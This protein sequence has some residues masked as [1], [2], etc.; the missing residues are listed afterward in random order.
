MTQWIVGV[1][2]SV[3]LVLAMGVSVSA[4]APGGPVGLI[5]DTDMGNDID[6]ALAL[7]VIHALETRGECKLLAVTSSKDNK[8][9]APFVDA[10][11]TFYGRGD[12]PIG[13]VRDGKEKGDG[14][15]LRP[16]CEA[17]DGDSLRY[18]HKLMSG[19]DAPEAVGLLRKVLAAQPDG[20][21]ILVVVGFSTNPARLLDS[22]ADEHSPLSGAELVAKKCRLLSNM[23]GHFAEGKKHKEYN[24]VLDIPAAQKVYDEWPTPIVTSGYEIGVAITY[25]ATSIERDFNYVPHH[26]VAAAYRA[27]MKFP[28]DRPTWDLTSV[29]YA[30]RP[31][32]DYFGLSAPGVIAADAEG[33]TTHAPQADGGHRFLIATPEQIIR[34]REALVQLASQPPCAK[35]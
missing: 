6:D 30:V 15:Y 24:I 17:R 8:F 23:A 3:L 18:P 11:N 9:S 21:V 26:P 28:Y 7:S 32:R 33:V 2:L 10:V 19:E 22:K 20:S 16:V 31:D 25:P 29:L 27:Y 12:I 1:S 4:A 35:P 14:T 13:V 34:V 5:F